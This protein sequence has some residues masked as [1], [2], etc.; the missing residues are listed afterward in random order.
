MQR[1]LVTPSL[2]SVMN[3]IGGCGCSAVLNT[4]YPRPSPK[5]HNPFRSF[6][7]LWE[8]SLRN[9][10]AKIIC[11]RRRGLTIIAPKQFEL[12][13]AADWGGK[14]WIGFV[15]VVYGRSS[16]N[17]LGSCN[18]VMM[19]GILSRRCDLSRPAQMSSKPSAVQ[20][21]S[22]VLLL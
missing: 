5:V 7:W 20:G 21:H 16:G 8:G 19:I 6:V 17:S 18:G 9:M 2:H 3:D 13:W 10:P 15:L 22:Q 4:M 12:L 1:N 14:N 11:N